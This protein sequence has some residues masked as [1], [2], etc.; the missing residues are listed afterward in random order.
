MKKKF[1]KFT[2]KEKTTVKGRNNIA[3]NKGKGRE[4]KEQTKE[5]EKIKRNRGT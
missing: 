1:Q 2:A 5:K 4:E 3:K